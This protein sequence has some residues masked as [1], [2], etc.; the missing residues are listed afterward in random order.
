[1]PLVRLFTFVMLLYRMYRR[2][3]KSQ[4]RQLVDAVGRYGPRAAE[5]AARRVRPR[6][7]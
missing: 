2:L 7:P 6:R 4:R 5:R 1:M 3:P